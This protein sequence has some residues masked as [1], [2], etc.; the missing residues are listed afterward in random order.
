MKLPTQKY[1]Q[2]L[3][4][5]YR[6]SAVQV[7]LT[8][9]LS[10]FVTA[11]F[12]VLAL[13][14][15]ITSIVTLRKTIAESEKILQKLDSKVKNLETAASALE[16]AKPYLSTLNLDIPNQGANY[17]PLTFAV[18]NLALQSGTTIESES[19]GST[20][21]F[22][23]IL[24]PFSPNKKQ[25]VVALPFSVRVSGSYG[26]VSMFLK[27]LLT[28]ERVISID[29]VTLSKEVSSKNETSQVALNI[30]GNAYYLADEAQLKQALDSSKGG[31]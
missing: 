5:Y 18:E 19:L 29:S 8:L 31:K 3:R 16:I 13:K 30:T 1:T 28:M 27:N 26:G 22:S 24:S 21:L 25:G 17:S 7:S 6:M 4:R 20:L 12:I 11:I 9:V 15:T 2:D 10:L 23:R 14:P